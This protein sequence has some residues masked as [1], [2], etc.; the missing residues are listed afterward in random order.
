MSTITGTQTPFAAANDDDMSDPTTASDALLVSHFLNRADAPSAS[1]F[2]AILDLLHSSS[3][4]SK[5]ITITS[6]SDLYKLYIN[7]QATAS[8]LR[9]R[10]VVSLRNF[11]PVVLDNIIAFIDA[12]RSHLTAEFIRRSIKTHRRHWRRQDTAWVQSI[13]PAWKTLAN[14]SLVHPSWTWPAQKAMGRQLVV[15]KSTSNGLCSHLSHAT[16]S[17]LYGFWTTDAY[18]CSGL[19]EKITLFIRDNRTHVN[20]TSDADD[21]ANLESAFLL[22]SLL[23]RLPSLHYLVLELEYTNRVLDEKMQQTFELIASLQGLR[24]LGVVSRRQVPQSYWQA[25][26]CTVARLPVLETLDVGVWTMHQT[27]PPEEAVFD[28][29]KPTN[30]KH[31]KIGISADLPANF[32]HWLFSPALLE[33]DNRGLESLDLTFAITRRT[34]G[35][36]GSALEISIIAINPLASFASLQDLTLNLDSLP[37]TE[38]LLTLVRGGIR[39]RTLRI[40]RFTHTVLPS[41]LAVLPPTLEALYLSLQLTTDVVSQFDAYVASWLDSAIF[42]AQ[43]TQHPAFHLRLILVYHV[44]VPQ[45]VDLRNIATPEL[46]S[47]N[48]AYVA[49]RDGKKDSD[50]GLVVDVHWKKASYQRYIIPHW[51]PGQVVGV[52]QVQAQVPLAF[53]AILGAQL[54]V[55]AQIAVAQAEADAQALPNNQAAGNALD[56][57]PGVDP[58]NG[59]H[60]HADAQADQQMMP[61]MPQGPQQNIDEDIGLPEDDDMGDADGGDDNYDDSEDDDDLLEMTDL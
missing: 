48:A 40:N 54:P 12:K 52:Q 31:L 55:P 23:S 41:I 47:V 37:S 38:T 61:A 28:A 19:I 39:L 9:S 32:L 46:P 8:S 1:T 29:P 13:D 43:R 59:V 58:V 44:Q 49:I 24:S 21:L 11:P 51:L 60:A 16:R 7:Q 22:S 34:Q 50:P 33:G 2:Q 26:A 30:L 57:V 14:M 25:L 5:L 35:Q 27:A 17:Q 10:R 45:G 53:A 20:S 4:D 18:I 56:D 15:R 6:P 36:D 3:F 42:R